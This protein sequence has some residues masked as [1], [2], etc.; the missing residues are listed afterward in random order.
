[1]TISRLLRHLFDP[2]SGLGD[3]DSL[4]DPNLFD[5]FIFTPFPRGMQLSTASAAI[6]AAPYSPVSV[7]SAA[8]LS[9]VSFMS[10][11][12]ANGA[13]LASGSPSYWTW[14]DNTPATYG[15]NGAA[16]LPTTVVTFGFNPASGWTQAEQ[17]SFT[18]A[19]ALWSAEANV[20]FALTT[21][22]NAAQIKFTRGTDG[23][24]Y[25]SWS[26]SGGV[27]T[28]ATVSI[29][30]S[31]GCWQQLG[32]YSWYGGY[33]ID[34]V[35]HELGHV[36]G[37]GHSGPY[38][39]SVSSSQILYST[40][41]RQYTIM[42]YNDPAGNPY[43]GNYRTTPGDYDILAAQR[44]Y[45]AP[46][47]TPLGGGQIFGFNTNIT[48]FSQ[49][50][51]AI[52][53]HP[54]VTLYDAGLNNTLDL[55]GFSQASIVDLNPGAFSSCAGMTNNLGIA[56]STRIDIA[57]GGSGN[58]SFTVNGDG[59]RIDGRGGTNTVVYL[60][61]R[62][63]YTIG[64]SATP[65]SLTV[66][67]NGVT[68]SLV[69][70]QAL[71]FT[72]QTVTTAQL[73]SSVVALSALDAT[74]AE[75]NNGST[76]F[77][78]KVTRTGSTGG[79]GTVAWSVTGSGATPAT[80][81]DFSGNVMPSGTISFAAGDTSKTITVNVAGDTLVE[82]NEGF[83]VTLSKPGA[84][85]TL[86]TATAGGTIV[87]DDVYS[88]SLAIS[89]NTPSQNEGQSGAT[90]FNFT[91]TR[92]GDTTGFAK[93]NWTVAGVKLSGTSAAD[94]SDFVGGLPSGT[95]N[96]APGQTSAQISV[97]VAGDAVVEANESFSVTLSSAPLGETIRTASASSTIINDDKAAAASLTETASAAH[98]VLAGGA[99][100][101]TFRFLHASDSPVGA[102][103]DVIV[104][105]NAALGDRIDLSAIDAN[106]LVPGRQ[107]FRFV[108]SQA[109]TGAPGEL[110]AFTSA[111]T[112]TILGSTIGDVATFQIELSNATTLSAANFYL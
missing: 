72:D 106:D 37:L 68:D 1:M 76:A 24:S 79:S 28:S 14:N 90:P 45:G 13:L 99:G 86:G 26:S 29:S 41:N 53:T 38:N 25:T 18:S 75:G 56:F 31:V 92:S 87:N 19:L 33:G 105:F 59:D 46:T 44:I 88:G 34:T 42:S 48:A 3:G 21:N 50:N 70:I 74:K 36:V 40:D 64:A 111:G 2:A 49:F 71:K 73:T 96:F 108:G 54:V 98:D 62:S 104:G 61:P 78:F 8:G 57:I 10:G 17:Y 83:T 15:A 20:R 85:I 110:R 81:A 22:Y 67:C 93:A 109:F 69:N 101:D 89:A 95:V 32:S 58:D 16:H 27:I 97:N 55:S 91:V 23:G 94:G 84:G 47:T 65:N 112:T 60:G 80:T 43:G 5:P 4:T 35:V 103:H 11:R 107:P 7:P 77:T 52:D 102:A 39:G 12:G 30:T 100:A 63:S 51:F 9:M 6:S 82:A 66:S